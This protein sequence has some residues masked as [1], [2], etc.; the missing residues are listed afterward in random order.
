MNNF[1][2]I[3]SIDRS[4]ETKRK[5]LEKALGSG[6]FLD[7]RMAKKVLGMF[8]LDPIAEPSDTLVEIDGKE[9]QKH[10]DDV[11]LVLNRDAYKS[12]MML[13]ASP[14]GWWHKEKSYGKYLISDYCRNTHKK[15][16]QRFLLGDINCTYSLYDINL[17]TAVFMIADEANYRY[18]MERSGSVPTRYL[19]NQESLLSNIKQVQR[20]LNQGK[21]GDS[22]V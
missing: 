4:D 17:R 12:N 18:N 9:Y 21:L 1:D 5:D 14:W 10:I 20:I 2:W 22:F 16:I 7:I 8:N 11:V 6:V 13:K 3:K 19:K 15:E